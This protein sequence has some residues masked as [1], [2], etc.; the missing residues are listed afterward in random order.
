[1]SDFQRFAVYYLPDDPALAAFGASWL[2]WDV[3]AG[4]ACAHLDV[5]GIEAFTA[6]PRKYG[7]HGT[8]KPPFRLAEGMDDG[9]LQSDVEALAAR[10]SPVKVDAMVA[11]SISHFVALVPEGDATDLAA[12][13]FEC[14]SALDSYRRPAAPEELARR[15][16]AG[17]T[18]AQEGYLDQWGYP[19]V[20]TEFRFH[21]TLTGALD[22]ADRAAVL[23]A[24]ERLLPNLPRPFEIGSIALVGER[25]DG[26]FELIQ[27]YALTG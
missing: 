13:A 4:E 8:L 26:R 14:V 15:R 6:T 1:M 16:A 5:A 21:L 11:S 25:T 20:D 19:Y 17:L 2:G 3:E 12:L 9:T 7:F 10:L 24:A 18:S 23:D 27:R 22:E